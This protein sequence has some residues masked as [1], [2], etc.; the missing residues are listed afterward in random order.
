METVGLCSSSDLAV[1]CIFGL[2]AIVGFEG[3][4]SCGDSGIWE[5]RE[6]V[7]VVVVRVVVLAVVL[8]VV[9]R[10]P[11]LWLLLLIVFLLLLMLLVDLLV[12]VPV[13]PRKQVLD[14][15][16]V[17][18]LHATAAVALADTLLLVVLS[19]RPHWRHPAPVQNLSGSQGKHFLAIVACV[20]IAWCFGCHL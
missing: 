12:A 19:D 1:Q 18:R 14:V 10:L 4:I 13:G 15:A 7:V 20:V 5:R 8:V 11:S 3:L 6:W 9:G 2:D 17:A 16:A